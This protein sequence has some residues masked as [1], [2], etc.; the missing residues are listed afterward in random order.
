VVFDI[1][2]QSERVKAAEYGEILPL[3]IG[4]SA[5]NDAL[6]ST[7]VQMVPRE[8]PMALSEHDYVNILYGKLFCIS[9]AESAV[10]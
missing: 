9:D 1:G 6:M 5:I 8:P 3:N 7:K 10:Q 4:A 2:A